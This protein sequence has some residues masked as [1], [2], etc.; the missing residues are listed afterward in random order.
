MVKKK[1]EEKKEKGKMKILAAGDIHGD[2]AA[3]RRLSEKAEKEK[4]DLVILAGDITSP[5]E[6]ENLIKPLGPIRVEI[7]F[8]PNTNLKSSGL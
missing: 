6:S 8:S 1:E 3:T 7:K 4:V 5:V 2:S